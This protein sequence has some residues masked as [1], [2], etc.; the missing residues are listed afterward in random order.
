MKRTLLLASL[1]VFSTTVFG[2]LPLYDPFADATSVG[3]TSYAVGAAVP[4]QTNGAGGV[5]WSA[6]GPAG[7]NNTIAADDLSIPGLTGSGGG[8]M[9]F[10]VSTGPSARMNLGSTITA[11]S[12]FYSFAFK[13]TDLGTLG[14]SGGFVAGFNNAAGDQAGTPTVVSTALMMRSISGDPGGFN[15]GVRKGTGTPAWSPTAFHVNDVIFVVGSYTFNTG[16]TTDDVASMWLNPDTSTYGLG[17]APSTT[18]NHTG[19]ADIN[20]PGI[21]SL[22]FWRRGNANAALE[23]AAMLADEIRVGA[24][25]AEVT[26]LIPEPSSAALTMAAGFAFLALRRFRSRA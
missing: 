8:S 21:A 26:T 14:T 10:G 11:G 17:S 13:A 9:L 20:S 12:V 24:T 3:G 6:A 23:P 16:S 18:L 4:G 5:G 25:W 2:A 15:I 7:V 1:T 19:V 22:V